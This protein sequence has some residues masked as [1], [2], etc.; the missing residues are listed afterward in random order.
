MD[1]IRGMTVVKE[2]VTEWFGLNAV[3][4]EVCLDV[5]A[6]AVIP[7][8]CIEDRSMKTGVVYN[9]NR[10][11]CVHRT[12]SFFACIEGTLFESWYRRAE[13]TSR[14]CPP[15]RLHTTRGVRSPL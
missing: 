8:E 5:D 7:Q 13:H 14:D 4:L 10:M 3:M 9:C 11:A 6:R 1:L 15:I 12:L 2:F